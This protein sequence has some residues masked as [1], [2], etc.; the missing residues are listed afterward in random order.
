MGRLFVVVVSVL[1]SSFWISASTSFAS[2]IYEFVALPADV[3]LGLGPD[4]RLFGGPIV[5]STKVIGSLEI[6]T[7]P[8]SRASGWSTVDKSDVIALRLDDTFFGLGS[9]NLAAGGSFDVSGISSLNGSHLDAGGIS[10]GRF[11]A[12]DSKIAQSLAVLAGDPEITQ[13]LSIFFNEGKGADFIG[14]ASEIVFRDGS[15]DIA[16]QFVNGDWDLAVVPE[17]TTLLLF[18]TTM[19]G[20]GLTARRRWRRQN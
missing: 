13:S 2:V 18:G 8:A 15:I 17:P 19:A 12:G 5:G 1:A 3:C 6:A 11:V 20:L 7:P 10:G 4:C 9:G 16:D 14:V